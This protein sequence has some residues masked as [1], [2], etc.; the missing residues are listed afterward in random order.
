M[1]TLHAKDWGDQWAF[2]EETVVLGCQ[3]KGTAKAVTV[4]C[5]GKTY[6]I[7]GNALELGYPRPEPIWR[8]NPSNPQLKVNLQPFIQLGL[9]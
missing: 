4:S 3:T 9:A 1:K 2:T 7:N 6:A 5:G 8:N